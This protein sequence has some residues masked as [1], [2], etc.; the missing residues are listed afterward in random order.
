MDKSVSLGIVIGAALSGAFSGAIGGAKSKLTE[1]GATVKKLSA[2]RGLIERFERDQSALEKARR[3]ASKAQKEVLALKAALR[4]DPE[5]AGLSQSLERAEAK[6]AKLTAA[7]EKEKAALRASETAM[8]KAGVAVKDYGARYQE[9]GAALERARARQEK[10]Q[11]RVAAKEAAGQ[12]L[13]DMKA[14]LVP[15]LGL[16][17]AGAR[18]VGEA[19]GFE[20]ELRLFG[21]VADLS[22][23]RLGQIRGQLVQIRGLT[24][25]PPG[26]LLKAL[27]D[28]TGKGLD[29]GRSVASLQ[30]IGKTAT[31][32]SAEMLDLSSTSF[33]LIDALGLAPE[34]LPK[35]LD[36]L[37]KAGKEGRFELKDMA[38][39]F[40]TL[41]AGAKSL[42]LVGKE[43]VATLA[44]ML[45]IAAKGAGTNEEAA[46]NFQN[47]I[48]KLTAPETVK[49][50]GAM[51]VNLEAVMKKAMAAGKNPLE[52]MLALVERLT[53]GDK[54][55]VGEL[56]GDMQVMNFLNPMLQNLKEY[57]QIKARTL[58]ASGV[59]DQD[60]ANMMQTNTE[61]VKSLK[62]N[63]GQLGVAF[64]TAL[65][66][67]VNAVVGPLGSVA[68]W[69]A[70]IV[71][72]APVVGSVITGATAAFAGYKAVTIGSTAAQWAL[73]AAMTANPIG[74]VVVGIGAAIA[75]AIHFRKEIAAG[76]VWIGESSKRL[77]QTIDAW[78]AKPL[79][80]IGEKWSAIR[81]FVGGVAASATVAAGTALASPTATLPATGPG[82]IAHTAQTTVH[83]PI[84]VYAAPGMDERKLAEHV[85]TKLRERENRA[86]ARGRGA[87]HD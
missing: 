56:F 12:R 18:M 68:S 82:M 16:A 86:A 73:N 13:G 27:G 72:K 67:T 8:Q 62:Q 50:F 17:Y 78:I 5:N 39:S 40:P 31:A 41:T 80:W 11:T 36:M 33:S 30:A 45:Q 63:V 42:G 19:S 46:T 38:K 54:F 52:E 23:E 22:N 2:E 49:R 61:Q 48:S 60:F 9:L 21:N 55:R 35:A 7:L 71:D 14:G 29:V 75:T 1:L 20:H 44:A 83:A 25:Q 10:F 37:A 58:A 85:D 4:K 24:N 66:P 51:G 81:G 69:L 3:G 64:G 47:F 70:L 32:T 79:A 53:K 87:L 28:L 65:L 15:A 57:Q 26:E 43:G 74:L 76:F 77:G 59:V 34:E 84:T 6:A